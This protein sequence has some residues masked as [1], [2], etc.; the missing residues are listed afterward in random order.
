[1][2]VARTGNAMR[3]A[4]RPLPCLPAL[5]CLAAAAPALA[6]AKQPMAGSAGQLQEVVITATKRRT[7]VQT[8]PISISVF[9]GGELASRGI[10]SL[11]SLV[12]SVP[13]IAVRDSGSPGLD[14]LEMR[15]LNSQGGNTSV[16]GLY[17]GSIPLSAPANSFFGKVVIDPDLYDLKRVEVLRGPQGTL[18]GS[19][20]MGGTIR[21]I[22]N[23][24]RLNAFRASGEEVIS[25]TTDGGNLNHQENAMVNI[26]LGKTAAVRL[27]GSFT[28]NSGFIKRLVIQNGAVAVDAGSFPYVSRPANFYR[29]PLQQNLSGVNTSSV[30]QIRA[31]LL[32]Q[33]TRD[34]TIYPMAMYESTYAG[35][36]DE[37]DVNG[38]PT[39][40]TLPAVLAHYEVFDAPEP[41][42]DVMS[43]G[44]LK[45]VYTRPWV[46]V[47]SATGYWHRNQ[48]ETED[49][50]ELVAPAI[51]IPAYD[52][53]AGGI[54]PN[55][56]P[57]GAGIGEQDD[58]HQLSEELRVASNRPLS[59]PADMGRLQW[60][61]GYFYQDLF[62]NTDLLLNAPQATPVLGGTE[63]FDQV[64]PQDIIQNAEY[65]HMSWL[66]TSRWTIEAGFR[67]Y[68]YSL[69][70]TN[71]QFGLFTPYGALG[72]LTTPFN[73]AASIGASGTVPSFT[74]MYTIN[75]NDMVYAKFS[76]GFRLG[77]TNQEVPVIAATAA[78][79][80]NGFDALLVS[81]ECAL[82]QKLLLTTACSSNVV[83]KAPETFA[84]DTL[85]SYEVGEKS[86][87]FHRRMMLDVDG[88]YERWQHPQIET[89][90]SGFNL[91]VTGSDARIYGFEGQLHALLP[92]GFRILLNA[93]YTNAQFL[94]DS[95]ITGFPAGSSIPDIPK[96]TAAGVLSWQHD[97]SDSRAVFGSIESDYVTDRSE[98]PL[99]VTATL[100]NINQVL[101]TLPAYALTNLR[102]GM[103]GFA[104]NGDE[105]T[106]TLFV[107]NLTNNLV[108]LDPQPQI[109]L[110]TTAFM[111][112]TIPRPLTLG[113]DL[114]YRM[115]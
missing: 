103:K 5:L 95:A 69:S 11:H 55:G 8:T 111:R 52:V 21:L 63:L 71:S 35:G 99:V 17:L 64:Q 93:A 100:Q 101:V 3:K 13:G 30:D 1:M 18:Y 79:E 26:P 59:L 87:F 12:V 22:P 85:L 104:S 44:S 27:V 54:G 80:A 94:H 113:I 20:S 65:G 28:R 49:S 114:T 9:T 72:E 88:Y 109:S 82:Q 6:R 61:F 58:T 67:H 57:F 97:L 15:G 115:Q 34:L 98:V 81:N 62:S 46:S 53:A 23:A 96:L 66:L 31:E 73:S 45:A 43:F 33:P 2:L 78:N 42:T 51:G 38:N 110:Q 47:T 32:W 84:S 48:I 105:W 16:V 37:V 4:L 112:Y 102:L 25:D 75:R 90:L 108:P 74:A 70:Q 19:S 14:E 56:S 50:T 24:P 83:L 39:H 29:A 40:P 77:G 60:L 107:D 36:P 86:A 91:T 106:A 7:T 89:A 76:K 92:R 41:Q 68:N 10:T